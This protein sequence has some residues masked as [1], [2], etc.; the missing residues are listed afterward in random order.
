MKNQN[1]TNI[2]GIISIL[3]G[4]FSIYASGW[5]FKDRLFWLSVI[6]ILLVL[7]FIYILNKLL[8]MIEYKST[9]IKNNLEETE[10]L[11]YELKSAKQEIENFRVITTFLAAENLNTK[12]KP[13]SKTQIK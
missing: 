3:I 10:S 12:A 9:E 11:K 1:L 8:T 7:S 5:D 13:R 4:I 2:Y 6:L